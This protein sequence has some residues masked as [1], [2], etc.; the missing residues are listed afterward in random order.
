FDD[1]NKSEIT[2]VVADGPGKVD[3]EDSATIT[4]SGGKAEVTLTANEGDSIQ[5]RVLAEGARSV[6]VEVEATTPPEIGEGPVGPMAL[7]LDAT[8][9]GDQGVRRTETAPAVGDELQVDLVATEGADGL[10]AFNA[11]IAYDASKLEF[12]SFSATDLFDGGLSIPV[13]SDGAVRISVAF[14]TSATT[15]AE[16]GSL[17]L[18]SFKVL[19]EGEARV[20]LVSGQ[21]ASGT[22]PDKLTIGTGGAVVG[23]G[24]DAISAGLT[25]SEGDG[26]WSMDL[27]DAAGDQ[28]VRE[29]NGTGGGQE[30]TIQL[31]NNQSISPSLGGSFTI[32]FDPQKVELV[33]GSVS[34][35]VN[36]LGSLV[37]EDNTVAFTLAGLSGVP[38]EDG[39]IG[40]VGFKTLDGF[41]G[42]TEIV[43]LV[44]EI[45][46]ATTFENVRSEPK[47]SVVI[48]SG[49]GDGDQAPSLSPDFDG[50]G[51]VGFRDFIQ[52]AQKYGAKDGDGVSVG[53]PEYEAKFD[54]DSSGEVGFRD[55]ILFAQSYGKDPSLFVV[56]K[57]ALSKPASDNGTNEDALL[58]L[59]SE[60]GEEDGEVM[61]RLHLSG[62]DLV[63][64]FSVRLRFDSSAMSWKGIDG[65]VPS[66]FVP[67]GEVALARSEGTEQI[68]LSD[69]L[70]QGAAIESDGDLVRLRFDMLDK[71]APG[72]IDIVQAIVS[73]GTGNVT[74]LLGIHSAELRSL[75]NTFSLGSNFPNPFNP[76]TVLPFSLPEAAIVRLAVF[77]I[78][79]QEVRVLAQGRI[80]AG[81]HKLVWDGK[82]DSGRQMASGIYLTRMVAGEFVGI[83]KMLMIK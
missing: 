1:D 4:V 14:V 80:E 7:D 28:E 55:F 22:E 5:V 49:T 35:I 67:A 60:P 61:V 12:V 37:F 48:R 2:F 56:P 62:V 63:D 36:Q 54:L 68:V 38:V 71:T 47:N 13:S 20:I 43:L 57:S 16:S 17:G 27:D 34:G 23:I 52:F 42:E 50:D 21:F 30:F 24:G 76:D 66:L 25:S 59:I 40:Q 53:L 11:A 6:L 3:G 58:S 78:L 33:S 75:P 15:S 8:S 72:R 32:Q 46:D 9:F 81:Y 77:N 18:F 10:I 73:D 44:A 69:I 31:I 19:A 45:G 82:D 74:R 65:L 29:L 26:T 79:G 64:G 70:P 83:N 41:E 51:T 39:Y